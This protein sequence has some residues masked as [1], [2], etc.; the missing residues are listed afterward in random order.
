MPFDPGAVRGRAHARSNGVKFGRKPELTAHQRREAAERVQA[1]E[2]QRS[3]ARSYNV[4]LS[5]IARLPSA[6]AVYG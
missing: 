4:S 5:T 1:G 2:P 3:V 6:G